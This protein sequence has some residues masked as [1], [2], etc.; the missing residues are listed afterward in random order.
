MWAICALCEDCVGR[1]CLGVSE[2]VYCTLD[3]NL[4]HQGMRRFGL[5]VEGEIMNFKLLAVVG[6]FVALPVM[7]S[8]KEGDAPAGIIDA[9]RKMIIL[10]HSATTMEEDP[11]HSRAVAAARYHYMQQREKTEHLLDEAREAV[12]LTPS[13]RLTGASL[14]LINH[15]ENAEDVR[16]GDLLAFID[17][18]DELLSMERYRLGE[19]PRLTAI[20]AL[21][22]RVE[23][24][25]D[26]YREEYS[27][28]MGEMTRGQPERESWESYIAAISE[29]H[30]VET[31]LE[32]AAGE[33]TVQRLEQLDRDR[34]AAAG[35]ASDPALGEPRV[36]WG[37]GLPEKT[38][39]LTF[40]DGP[41][42]RRTNRVLD[43]LDDYGAHGYFFTLG[44]KLGDMND[45]GTARLTQG[46]ATARRIVEEGHVLA[47]HSFSHSNFAKLSKSQRAVELQ[48]TNQLIK[49][50]GGHSN[51]LFR[52]PYGVKDEEL[53]AL[54]AEEGMASIMWN[55][56]SMDWADPLPES[57]VD[58]TIRE[59][60]KKKRGILLF[61]DIHNQ[62]VKA[63][64][65]ILDALAAR[66]YRVVAL[67]GKPFTDEG[68]GTLTP[69]KREE[70][71]YG[72][73]WAVVIGI[74]DYD[75]WPDLEYAVN[76]ARSVGDVLAEQ[77]DF[78]EDNIIRLYDGEATRE[79]ITEV[80][81]YEMADP[82]RIGKN[83][84]VFVFFSG[85]GT[86]RPLP[87]GGDLGYLIPVDAEVQRY[88]VR[89]ISMS[90]LDNFSAA[91]PAKHV[92]FVMDSCYSGL[93][94]TRAGVNVGETRNYLQRVA[95]RRARQMLTA[96]GADE[97]VADGGPGG[98]SIF[99][100]TFLKALTGMA[101]SDDNGY[102]SASELGTYI[103]P[104]VSSY[105]QQ[106][107][108]FGNLVGSGGGDFVFKVSAG[109]DQAFSRQIAKAEGATG[110]ESDPTPERAD[111]EQEELRPALQLTVEEDNGTQTKIR[112]PERKP[113]VAQRREAN[114]HDAR[115]LAL[116]RQGKLEEARKEWSKAAQLDPY[117]PDI[118]NNYGFVLD[119]LG[120]YD[121][122]LKWYYRTVE[123]EPRRT[124][125]YLNLG[126]I[127][128][129]MDRP[130]DAIPY[131]ER[132]LH[133]YPS[134]EKA[135]E[136]RKKIEEISEQLEQE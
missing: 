55:I 52:P 5:G 65:D 107:P 108:V 113:D 128:L 89:G 56:D 90:E 75:H 123:L 50:V 45:D 134:Y 54:A 36:V 70:E 8:D 29:A 22:E 100:W 132:Y 125:I 120:E 78:P 112:L 11:R 48:N 33:E 35:E 28:A 46:S 74:N 41:H 19:G 7:A 62:T 130:A 39:V 92:F 106:T 91:I 61:H 64:P 86:T 51:V 82:E 110:G 18:V 77:L 96:G 102:V 133:L 81:G 2:A 58:R 80:L 44:K 24:V 31:L 6:M 32:D 117:N 38:V 115:A 136:L 4:A 37:G 34:A 95:S 98:H 47:N 99:T 76:D 21:D 66:G 23:A 118:V 119:Q 15:I 57:I 16:D 3:L 73:S 104:A 14:E 97:E 49:A 111:G 101:D 103:A 60:E 63:L 126:D 72:Q 84:R 1:L 9:Y 68:D 25:L 26:D 129:K 59:L 121:N 83:D 131:Y 85:H 42:K 71:L 30:S 12:A 93:G 135:D 114:K 53:D 122:A 13:N 17:L 105:A 20:R 124:P 116:F 79:R 69:P 87:A 10:A 27:R 94:L 67:D 109:A 88:Q 40:D 127:M 43:V